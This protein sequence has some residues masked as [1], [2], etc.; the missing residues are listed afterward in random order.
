MQQKF[1]KL[2]VGDLSGNLFLVISWAWTIPA[3]FKYIY[4]YHYIYIYIFM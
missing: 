2:S 3:F 4:I 1:V